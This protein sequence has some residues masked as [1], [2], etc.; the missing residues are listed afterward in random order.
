MINIYLMVSGYKSATV[1]EARA[2]IDDINQAFS[3][4]NRIMNEVALVQSRKGDTE[5]L[6]TSARDWLI[7]MSADIQLFKDFIQDNKD[8]LNVEVTSPDGLKITSGVQ[9]YQFVLKALQERHDSLLS[10]IV[11]PLVVGTPEQPSDPSFIGTCTLVADGDSIGV[12]GAFYSDQ[13]DVE[14]T[15]YI[16]FAGVNSPEGGTEGGKWSQLQLS[17]LLL[18]KKVHIYVDYTQK[19]DIFGRWLGVPFLILD[20][21]TEFDVNLW[22]LRNC[23]A[24]PNLKFGSHHFVDPD[25]YKRASEACVFGSPRVGIWKLTSDPA[26]ATVWIDGSYVGVSGKEF[27]LPMGPHHVVMFKA[28]YSAAHF[29]INV[30]EPT[31]QLLPPVILLKLPTETALVEIHTN[32]SNILATVSI[33]GSLMGI[34]PIVIDLPTTEFST[35]EAWCPNYLKEMV[36]V[37]P[38]LG[39][40]KLVEVTLKR[41]GTSV[42]S[43]TES[44]ASASLPAATVFGSSDLGASQKLKGRR[45]ASVRDVTKRR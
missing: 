26:H 28:G 45:V 35:V 2:R 40:V 42:E 13:P 25:S 22:L 19:F 1:A 36:Y 17:N 10:L 18:G 12:T 38:V 3:E 43:I 9:F 7:A 44:E 16:R 37:Q 5:P 20:D 21:G 31:A 32:P 41:A 27:E 14:V 29:D 15:R 4:F 24:M 30:T 33:N 39:E 6:Y 34:A 11:T 23:L 8:D